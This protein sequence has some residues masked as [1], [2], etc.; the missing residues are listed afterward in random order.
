MA[1]PYEKSLIITL[2]GLL[3]L[4]GI[5]VGQESYAQRGVPLPPPP[6]II[7][8]DERSADPARWTQE[9]VTQEQKF[10][11]ARKEAVAAQQ[12]ALD[13]CKTL[14]ISDQ[15]LCLAQSKLAFEKEMAD[16]KTTFGITR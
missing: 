8:P 1:K 11:T 13:Y 14:A 5:S 15:A 7:W 6:P 4:T 16:I 9:D 12:I 3:F 10:D 2:S